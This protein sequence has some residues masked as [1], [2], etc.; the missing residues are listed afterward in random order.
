M[1]PP[2]SYEIEYWDGKAWRPTA[3]AAKTPEKPTGGR[4]NTATF[5]RVTAGKLRIVFAHAGKPRS[6]VSEVMV[7]NDE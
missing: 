7:W 2:T 1:Q 4:F 3:H 5:D 6:G